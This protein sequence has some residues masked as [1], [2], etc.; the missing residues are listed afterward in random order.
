MYS[1]K[2]GPGLV[3]LDRDPN[4]DLGLE[5][6]GKYKYYTFYSATA[7]SGCEVI[8]D[9]DR[10]RELVDSGEDVYFVDTSC[11]FCGGPTP[12]FRDD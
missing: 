8:R 2:I 7:E 10:V 4:T 1:R 3:S 12:C 9:L 6:P 11:G 5:A